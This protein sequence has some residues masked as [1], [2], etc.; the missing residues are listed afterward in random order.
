MPIWLC[1]QTRRE[2]PAMRVL[3]VILLH[4]VCG[5][6]RMFEIERSV[7]NGVLKQPVCNGRKWTFKLQ[8]TGY[9]VQTSFLRRLSIFSRS[10]GFLKKARAPACIESFLVVGEASPLMT[11]TGMDSCF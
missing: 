1:L 4:G 10:S 8:A 2:E 11:I 6:E 9:T 7:L 5:I 3:C